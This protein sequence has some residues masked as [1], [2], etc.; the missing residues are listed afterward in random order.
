MSVGR[1]Y[2]AACVAVGAL[3]AT[4]AG[5]RA[6][7]DG[8]ERAEI[9]ELRSVI[10]RQRARLDEQRERLRRQERRLDALAERL[11]DEPI[12]LSRL[13]GAGTPAAERSA[14]AA[15]S[16]GAA[17]AG[18]QRTAQNRSV[19]APD[20]P[21]GQPGEDGTAEEEPIPVSGL[22]EAGGI[23]TPQG[24][25]VFEPSIEYE[26]TS[27]NRFF[28]NGVEIIE[29]VLV[30]DIEVTDA[31]RDSV[32]AAGELR[33][34]LTDRA[35]LSLRVPWVYRDDRITEEVVGGGS[36]TQ[37]LTAADV[38]DVEL[39]GRYQFNAGGEGWPIFIGNLRLK[40]DTGTGPFDVDQDAGVDQELSTGSGFWGIQPSV[41]TVYRTDPAVLY[42]SLSYLFNVPENVDEV[43]NGNRIGR[44]DPGDTIGAGIGM[45]FAV[46]QDLSFN[47][48][49]S[50][51]FVLPTEQ[52]VNGVVQE[53]N[54]FDVGTLN[55]GF[56]LGLADNYSI[57]ADIG[58]GVTED[59]PDV[60]VTFST[61]LSFPLF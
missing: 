9:R 11:R 29:T 12:G 37:N 18:S 2:A 43:S 25:L 46:N 23:L 21:V 57:S 39:S 44:V 54:G 38:G 32:T 5:A 15:A 45:G 13:R 56:S 4:A 59:A 17:R 60:T 55:L 53:S 10:E 27:T 52:E 58:V 41:T 50:H 31:D 7:Q 30:G 14:G 6:G 47:L 1:G 20:E 49:Y 61:P 24:T 48:G 42:G 40:S 51:S 8:P 26:Q 35:E 28:F 22:R 36:T 16:P 3:A 34:G 19:D 33:Y